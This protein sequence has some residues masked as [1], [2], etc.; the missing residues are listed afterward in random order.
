MFDNNF[1]FNYR[2]RSVE[3]DGELE[4][5]IVQEEA[6][7]AIGVAARCKRNNVVS[8]FFFVF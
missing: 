6:R 4:M 3:N 7:K 8:F 5:N 1:F 2:L